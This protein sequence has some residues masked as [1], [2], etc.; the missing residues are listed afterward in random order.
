MSFVIYLFYYVNNFAVLIP[1]SLA[2]Q[3]M[4]FLDWFKIP[5]CFSL[6]FGPSLLLHLLLICLFIDGSS[7]VLK[8]SIDVFHDIFFL[9]WTSFWKPEIFFS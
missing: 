6:E 3:K 1:D 9:F 8:Q 5:L 4:L 7:M 2:F